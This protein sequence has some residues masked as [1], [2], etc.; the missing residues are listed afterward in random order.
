MHFFQNLVL[1]NS[2]GS[3]NISEQGVYPFSFEIT[4]PNYIKLNNK[5][6]AG[7]IVSSYLGEVDE[8]FLNK[9]FSIDVDM[10]ISMFYEHKP[11]SEVLKE[12]TYY[13]GN[14]GVELKNTSENQVDS[15]IMSASYVDAK[16]IKK[17]IQMYGDDF[18][19]LYIY[20]FVFADSTE[21]LL[22][23]ISKV[24]ATLGNVGLCSRNANYRQLEVLKCTLP[25]CQNNIDIKKYIR[26]NILT[27][28]LISTYPF[29]SNE[30]CDESGI[31]IGVN[32]FNNSL[33][34]L[35]RFKSS[36]YKNAN[37]CIIGT[38]GSGKS[39]FTKL[40]VLRNRYLNIPQYVI[41]PEREY[42]KVCEKLGGSVI[43]F[44]EGDIINVMEIRETVNIE[45]GS[46]LQDKLIKLN[47]FF[48]IIFPGMSQEEKSILEEK[49]IECYLKKGI[50]FD[51][52][53][54]YVESCQ[55]NSFLSCKR[56][57]RSE[58]MPILSDLYK[59]IKNDKSM[60][61]LTSLLK[62]FI[63]GSMHFF[64][65][66]TNVDLSKQ[67]VVANIYKTSEENLPCVMFVI[68][69]LFWDKIKSSRAQKKIIYIDEVCRLISNN[70][71][72][73]S[74]VL[75]MFKTIRKYGGA[76]T[77]ITQDIQDFFSLESGKYG[78]S[79][80]NNSSIK[81]IFQVEENDLNILKESIG[82]SEEELNMVPCLKR[83][84]CLLYAGAHHM[85]ACVEASSKEHQL[86]STNREDELN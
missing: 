27:S 50:T 42:I 64:N 59:L 26:R 78:R 51:N 57:K 75:K 69:E 28:G 14:T 56:F 55:K 17:Q 37:M 11:N 73:A 36:E 33:I 65:G 83:G 80:L 61:K 20:I 86:I 13:I 9:I 39:Y 38:S 30:L 15:D 4:N 2:L 19:Y 53:S 52:N 24:Q 47:A 67:L 44:E 54:L 71:E 82:M 31:L 49:T 68:T 34:M 79:I 16:Y 29:L 43:S 25:I 7:V 5:Y 12:I 35:D 48:S 1:S 58:D 66:Y 60:A 21:Q 6:S 40:M 62:P 41:D 81:S 3:C 70:S 32:S 45:G 10:Q 18:Y 74:F 22:Q 46:F 77:A 72:T 63:S 76:A 8:V 23:D 85:V 84:A